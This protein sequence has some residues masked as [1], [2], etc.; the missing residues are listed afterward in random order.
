MATHSIILSWKIPEMEEYGGLKSMGS[1]RVR[2]DWAFAHTY[3]LTH[4]NLVLVLFYLKRVITPVQFSSLQSLSHFQ[5]F[6]TPWTTAHQASL[7]ITS[8]WS[9]PKELVMPSKHLILCCPLLLLPSIFHSIRVFS[10]SQFLTLGGQS[11][12]ASASASVLSMNIQDWFPLGLIGLI[13]LQSKGQSRVFSNTTVQSINSLAL[14]LLYGPT[15]KFIHDY[16]KN[17]S[18]DYVNLC[19]QSDVSVF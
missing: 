15:L 10:V 11:I 3:T 14:S 13:S 9:V 7:S 18:F 12:K 5:L 1:Q 19:R 8:S 2:H 16:W 6:T 4:I 17:H